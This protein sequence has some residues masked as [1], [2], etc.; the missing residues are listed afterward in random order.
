MHVLYI[1]KI[2]LCLELVSCAADSVFQK[3]TYDIPQQGSYF[4]FSM[5]PAKPL[6]TTVWV[7]AARH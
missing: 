2:T 1:V 4:P 7:E 5:H 6:M 3:R